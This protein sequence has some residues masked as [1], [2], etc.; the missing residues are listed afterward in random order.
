MRLTSGSSANWSTNAFNFNYPSTIAKLNSAPSYVSL[1]PIVIPAALT[2]AVQLV[3]FVVQAIARGDGCS[4]AG[5]RFHCLQLQVEFNL[6][7]TPVRP[8]L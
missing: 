6:Y 5:Y 8:T 4:C 7:P 2:N 1:S 3:R